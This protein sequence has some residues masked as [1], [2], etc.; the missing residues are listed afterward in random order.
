MEANMEMPA[1][2]ESAT[3]IIEA[4]CTT[5]ICKYYVFINAITNLEITCCCPAGATCPF[6]VK[7]FASICER[8]FPNIKQVSL[9]GLKQL[10][11]LP[12]NFAV[13]G[14]SEGLDTLH[15]VECGITKENFDRAP[16]GV[17]YFIEEI[18]FE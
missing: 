5:P 7:S 10:T 16:L 4:I 8:S 12:H 15:I 3:F 6:T 17:K 1:S 9:I 11:K 14:D 13:L 18:I 2:S